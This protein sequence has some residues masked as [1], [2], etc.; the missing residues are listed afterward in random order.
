TAIAAQEAGIP[1]STR[2]YCNGSYRFGGRTYTCWQDKGHGWLD[3]TG[4]IKHSCDTYYWHTASQLGIDAI[5]D[6]AKRYGLGQTFD[7]GIGAEEAGIVPST[8]WKRAYYRNDPDNQMWFP[9]ETLSVAIGQGAVTATP[10]QLAVMSARI[11]THKEVRPRLVRAQGSDVLDAPEFKELAGSPYHLKAVREGMNQVV[12]EWGTASRSS[13]QPDFLMAGKTGTGQVVGLKRDPETGERLK[14]EDL[15]WRLRDHAL[16]VA[17]APYENP[18]YACSVVVEHGGSGSRSAGP[19]A[20]DIMR[21]VLEK[22]PA[23]PDK[24]EFWAGQEQQDESARFAALEK[25]SD[26]AP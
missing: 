25:T 10:I 19:R 14:N 5:A 17:F 2:V 20:R 4:A 13:L 12:N 8:A 1:A 18:R 9:G 7:L 3:M 23:N 16:F 22:D 21:A 11:A 15:P 24:H 6:V 26:D